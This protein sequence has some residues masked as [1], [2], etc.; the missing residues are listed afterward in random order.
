LTPDAPPEGDLAVL[1]S[2]SAARAFAN[3]RGRAPVIA[4]G[5]L[6]AAEAEA[7]GLTLRSVAKSHDLDGILDEIRAL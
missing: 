6:T 4:I 2:P 3:A 7:H 5:P 1:M